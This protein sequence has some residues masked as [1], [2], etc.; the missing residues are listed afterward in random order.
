M[1]SKCIILLVVAAVVGFL[2]QSKADVTQGS[3][4]NA[5]ESGSGYNGGGIIKIN[6]LGNSP[7]VPLAPAGDPVP[8]ALEPVA[9]L[10]GV[11]L[12]SFG[13]RRLGLRVLP[14]NQSA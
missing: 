10:A 9:L 7:T 1:K 6:P 14:R 11:C 5:V 2:P 3:A 12:V 4:D 13:A 8:D